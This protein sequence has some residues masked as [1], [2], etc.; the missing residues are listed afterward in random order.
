MD[1]DSASFEDLACTSADGLVP[2]THQE[3]LSHSRS[4]FFVFCFFPAKRSLGRG[5]NFTECKHR[6]HKSAR[7]GEEVLHE[8]C[9]SLSITFVHSIHPGVQG[10]AKIDKL[11]LLYIPLGVE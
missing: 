3:V 2:A 4:P 11:S 6:P 8:G 9:I 5:K 10:F 7:S 1:L